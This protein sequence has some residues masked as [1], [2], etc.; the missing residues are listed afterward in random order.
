MHTLWKSWQH[1]NSDGIW[2]DYKVKVFSMEFTQ[3]EW[4]AML[5]SRGICNLTN[6]HCLAQMN[7]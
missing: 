3:L 2:C 4:V 5:K 6:L 7:V 1:E